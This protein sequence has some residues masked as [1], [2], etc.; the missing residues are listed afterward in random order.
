MK[1]ILPLLLFLAVFIFSFT[2]CLCQINYDS[3][4]NKN[5]IIDAIPNFKE[6]NEKKLSKKTYDSIMSYDKS[7]FDK[8]SFSQVFLGVKDSSGKIIS[9]IVP[10]FCLCSI[11][12]NEILVDVGLFPWLSFNI[13]IYEK[14]FDSKVS[15]VVDG[16][17]PY[18]KD[19][20]DSKELNGI[21]LDSKY[22]NLILKTKPIFEEGKQMEG[23]LFFTSADYFE[24]TNLNRVYSKSNMKAKIYFKCKTQKYD[25]NKFLNVH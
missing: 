7:F 13:K 18:K 11:K 25:K 24:T 16:G 4:F 21:K 10:M 12:S 22:Q 20:N 5:Y 8:N 6:F 19:I 3:T 14:D 1:A 23:F 2:K 17:N 15:L 9:G